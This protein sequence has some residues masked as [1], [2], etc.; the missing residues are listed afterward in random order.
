VIGP[1]GAIIGLVDEHDVSR[2]YVVG[3]RDHGT[4]TKPPPTQSA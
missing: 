1:D 2:A 4:T 3:D